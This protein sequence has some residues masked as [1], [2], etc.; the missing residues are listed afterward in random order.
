MEIKKTYSVRLLEDTASLIKV[1]GL[2][3]L[4]Q[5]IINLTKLDGAQRFVEESL[6]IRIE[7]HEI[8]LD[9]LKKI[10]KKAKKQLST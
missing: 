10:S 1:L 8:Q 9:I 2:G 5:G 6:R 3:S 4:S 7:H